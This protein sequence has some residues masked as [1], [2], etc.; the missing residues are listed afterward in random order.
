MS[1]GWIVE[2]QIV[3]HDGTWLQRY[4]VAISDAQEAVAAVRRRFGASEAASIQVVEELF[5]ATFYG[6]GLVPGDILPR[7]RS[8]R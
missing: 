6:L 7:I 5:D 8:R 1:K 3:E 4:D 2:V